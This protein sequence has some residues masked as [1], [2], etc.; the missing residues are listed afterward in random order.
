MPSYSLRINGTIHQVEAQAEMPLLWVLRDLI[1]LTG[2]KYGCGRSRC[3][4]CTVQLNGRAVRSCSTPV[5][6]VGDREVIT[7]E[8]L[9]SGEL[10]PVQEAWIQEDVPQCGYCQPGQ[11][12]SASVLLAGNPSP[13]QA[14]IDRAMS[15][16]ICRCGT[17]DRIR[18]AIRRA[19]EEG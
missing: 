11:V 10:T 8:G 3:G 1:G 13:S 17:Y 7:I 19:A 16:N 14:D 18:K 5:S 4:A 2:T 6:R 12:V 9:S 15:R